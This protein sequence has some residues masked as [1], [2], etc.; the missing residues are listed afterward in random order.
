MLLV[1]D[2]HSDPAPAPQTKALNPKR[3]TVKGLTMPRRSSS[4]DAM[5]QS[6][7]KKTDGAC[8]L[9]RVKPRTPSAHVH[10]SFSVYDHPAEI[11][12]TVHPAFT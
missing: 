9:R 12:S 8:V 11:R 10:R 3:T 5:L 4:L 7:S 1:N 6:R 2:A